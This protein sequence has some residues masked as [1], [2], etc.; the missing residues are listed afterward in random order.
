L[1]ARVEDASIDEVAGGRVM[2][3]RRTRRRHRPGTLIAVAVLGVASIATI[4][5]TA[6]A[7][8]PK[9]FGRKATRVGTNGDDT[10]NGTN[11]RDVIVAKRGNDTIDAK[12]GRD[13]ICSGGGGFD[14][15]FARSGNDRIAAE[16]GF[17]VVFPGAGNDFIHGG[18]G[19]AFA[20]Y[21]GSSSPIRA[22]LA[23]GIIRGQGRDQLR[24]VVGIGGSEGDDVL[25]GTN[26][27]N[28]LEGFGGDDTIR[29]RGGEFDFINAGAGND[30]IRGGPGDDL[31]DMVVA[32]GGPGIGDDTLATSGVTANMVAGTA[33]GGADVGTDIFSGI[34]AFGATMGNDTV[35]GTDDE[36]FIATWDG[37][38]DLEGAG[39]DDFLAPGLGD[40]SVDGG[41]GEDML[42]LF[43]SHPFEGG[44]DGPVTVDL[45][46]QSVTGQGTDALTSIERAAGT[47]LDDT[48]TGNDA[49][50]VLIGDEGSDTISGQGGDDTLDGDAL[51]FD[52]PPVLPG[53]DSLDGGSGTD[54]C[55]RG[56]T[57]SN[58]ESS[59]LPPP[60]RWAR[61]A[62]LRLP[63]R[64]LLLR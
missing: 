42:E 35:V 55:V 30:N 50:N 18:R 22:N 9:C 33:T 59:E 43:P 40:D 39:S 24:N 3:N 17:D 6:N 34:E 63:G 56:E 7:A 5:P 15:V 58:C 20:T 27:F 28:D 31:L 19:G 12:G 32:H 4:V 53:T 47:A 38:D 11:G 8:K 51:W 62:A 49:A 57:T 37:T 14:V 45:G 1:C 29:A 60:S 23:S 52:F 26:D 41:A 21:E 13:F 16:R 10:I 44:M 46:A 2:V 54:V 36:N 64:M 48:L 61:P 25:L